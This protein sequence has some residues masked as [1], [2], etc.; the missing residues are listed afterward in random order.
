MTVGNRY[1]AR[2][3]ASDH[4]SARRLDRFDDRCLDHERAQV[5]LPPLR[6]VLR[7]ML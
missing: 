2:D 4:T 3:E 7:P 5:A 6:P 1:R